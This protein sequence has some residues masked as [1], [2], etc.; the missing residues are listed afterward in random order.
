M[1]R[2]VP[3]QE[4]VG[5]LRD[6]LLDSKA[7]SARLARIAR[8]KLAE[9]EGV[10][11]KHPTTKQVDGREGADEE[12]VKPGGVIVYLIHPFAKFI[13]QLILD[14]ISAS[15]VGPTKTNR[16]GY[17]AQHYESMWKI[18]IN[19][20]PEPMFSGRQPKPGEEWTI[21]NTMPYAKRIGHGWS[22][23]APPLWIDG[24]AKKYQRQYGNLFG[25]AGAKGNNLKGFSYS[26]IVPPA[27]ILPEGSK[28]YGDGRLPAI[29][30]RV[31]GNAV[32]T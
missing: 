12:S 5:V 14:L 19:G 18:L 32:V 21:V 1:A 22:A 3:I 17:R 4:L 15:P 2:Y 6:T 24:I 25:G 13:D 11:G 29:I 27:S 10:Q 26:F 20:V 16:A 31:P 23:Q 28:R 7:A 8:A 9:V 30:V